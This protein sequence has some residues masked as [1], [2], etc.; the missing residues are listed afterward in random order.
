M[1][2]SFNILLAS[3]AV[4]ACTSCNFLDVAPAK[5]ADLSDAMKNK[6][7][8]ENWA[9]GNYETVHVTNPIA[10]TNYEGS[11]DEYVTPDA[12]NEH[13]RQTVAYGKLNATNISDE[14]W[15]RFYGSIGN[16]HLFL[17]ELENQNPPFLTEDDKAL[18]VANSNFLKGYYYFKALSLFGPCPK[19][20]SYQPTDTPKE[21]FPG[22][23]HFDYMVDYVCDLLDLAMNTP[24]FPAGYTLD[25]TYG[26]GNKTVCAALKS[27]MLLYAASPLWNGDFPYPSWSNN[28]S[29]E[30][31]GYGK[32]LVSKEFSLDKW[33]R[34][35]EAAEEAIKIAT[36]EGQRKLMDI[37]DIKSM[38]DNDKLKP[39]DLY[40]PESMFESEEGE[41]GE[42]NTAARQEFLQRVMLMRYVAASDEEMG[43]KELIF[44]VNNQ[45]TSDIAFASLPRNVIE[46]NNGEWFSG[47]CGISPT[48]EMVEAF[49]T[50]NGKLPAKDPD[51]PDES[52]WLTSANI[53][54]RTDIIKLNVNREPRFY[55]WILY[56]GC[57]VGP[58][59][60]DGKPLTLDL[61]RTDKSG[62]DSKPSLR[63]QNQTGYL[64]NKFTPVDT[65]WTGNSNSV[66]YF[67]APLI[68]LAEL[69][70]N[71]AECCAELYMNTGDAAELDEALTNLNIIRRR[72]GVP[73]LKT[74]DCT[75]D[76]TI[77][78]WV[79]AERRIELFIEG[80]RYYDLRRWRI[81][82]EYLEEGARTGLNS[83]VSRKPNLTFSEFNQRVEVDGDYC[84]Y[85]RMYLLP[86]HQNEVYN[87][88]QMVQAPGY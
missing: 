44:T 19:V 73:E 26:R 61:K 14:Y 83:F 22:R 57:D 84:W 16:V 68:R 28:T 35:K 37:A 11:T 39:E 80:H 29:F 5:R 81:A 50:V 59:L 48:L 53:P 49:Y 30:T 47:F 27:R 75:E 3:L 52:Q 58:V 55:A 42:E 23:Y 60:V 87:N 13:N 56:D 4:L 65:R 72:A 64:N 45:T 41:E 46:N 1:K 31:P 86:L 69:Y 78:D 77:R 74:A 40:I 54:D 9:F 20:D 88:P 10:F 33:V 32:E 76:M 12:W 62:Y 24:Q 85:D 21:E 79:R 7:A 2:L 34:A 15:R 71:L 82:D 25:E 70:L 6:S 38:M 8:V 17:R 63:D 51:F 43:N 36:T 66:D 67:P 18:Y